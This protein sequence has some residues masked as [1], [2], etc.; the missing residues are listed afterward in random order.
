MSFTLYPAPRAESRA[1]HIES[2][3]LNHIFDLLLHTFSLALG[4][5]GDFSL[6]C[7]ILLLTF[8]IYVFLIPLHSFH[9]PECLLSSSYEWKLC[10]SSNNHRHHHHRLM[11]IGTSRMKTF[12]GRVWESANWNATQPANIRMKTIEKKT[13]ELKRELSYVN[14]IKSHVMTYPHE[15]T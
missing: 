5:L 13:E 10:V 3:A 15:A 11:N 9:T 14:L 4:W 7:S 8:E 12:T 1:R 6:L 2:R